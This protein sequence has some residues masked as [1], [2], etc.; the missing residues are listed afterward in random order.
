ME[1]RMH[2]Q[3]HLPCLPVFLLD[4]RGVAWHPA[5]P[6]SLR[7]RGRVISA[8][9]GLRSTDV[10]KTIRNSILEQTDESETTQRR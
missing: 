5:H 6:H 9:A 1:T 10:G 2:F 7:R 8:G 3:I 4:K